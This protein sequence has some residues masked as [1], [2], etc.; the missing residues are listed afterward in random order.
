M[1]QERYFVDMTV[2]SKT[3]K[4]Y[5]DMMLGGNLTSYKVRAQEGVAQVEKVIKATS[6][7]TG[8]SVNEILSNRRHKDLVQ[9]RHIAMFLAHEM[10]TL[11]YVQ[12]GAAMNKDHTSV[13]YAVN[14]IKKRGRGV[15]KVNK[16]MA[17]IKR[18]LA[19]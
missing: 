12:I 2:L 13:M 10:T 15:S 5:F 4:T 11:S 7:V 9:A 3:L 6:R 17:E 1:A 8:V 18:V 16:H 14:K 19:A